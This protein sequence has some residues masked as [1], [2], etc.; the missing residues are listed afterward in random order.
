[1]KKRDM[2][3]TNGMGETSVRGGI[4]QETRAGDW[5]RREVERGKAFPVLL[6]HHGHDDDEVP[7]TAPEGEWLDRLERRCDA[8]RSAEAL[9][10]RMQDEYDRDP[11]GG[12]ILELV[13]ESPAGSI[14]DWGL[15][16]NGTRV[17]RGSI[18]Y[19]VD[20]QALS[21]DPLETALR[22]AIEISHVERLSHQAMLAA[23]AVRVRP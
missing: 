14:T 21:E 17:A 2:R 10:R 1:M 22:G 8:C 16:A 5:V 12:W 23:E 20:G 13:W 15:Y 11:E 7:P 6:L 9:V 18:D 19:L 3:E 4:A